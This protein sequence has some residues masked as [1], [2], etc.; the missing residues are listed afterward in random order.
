MRVNQN[1]ARHIQTNSCCFLKGE[2][3]VVAAR[4]YSKAGPI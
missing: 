4:S 3:T 2:L 1:K